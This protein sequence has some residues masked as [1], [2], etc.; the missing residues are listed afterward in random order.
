MYAQKATGMGSLFD[1]LSCSLFVNVCMLK[2]RRVDRPVAASNPGTSAN[3][4]PNIEIL[5]EEITPR[6]ATDS[7]P[8]STQLELKENVAYGQFQHTT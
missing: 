4:R 6:Y 2:R 7:A 8:S 3:A 1:P 5:Y